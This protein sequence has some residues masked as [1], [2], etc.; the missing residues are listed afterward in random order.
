MRPAHAVAVQPVDGGWIPGSGD[1]E[2]VLPHLIQ[3]IGQCGS[4]VERVT[5]RLGEWS[6]APK[7]MRVGGLRVHL[8]GYHRQ[9][10]HTVSLLCSDGSR[11]VM[12]VVP[13][14]VGAPVGRA[15][16]KNAGREGNTETV[17]QLLG[18]TLT[19]VA[20]FTDPAVAQQRW[21]TDGGPQRTR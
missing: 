20:P 13:T 5:Y 4:Q 6:H 18:L 2:A 15:I 7:Q 21:D 8:D 3:E 16:M 9:P 11:I 10:R 17:Q 12:L 14:S 1:L 19:D